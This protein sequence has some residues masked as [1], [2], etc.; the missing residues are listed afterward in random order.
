MMVRTHDAEE[1]RMTTGAL[2]SSSDGRTVALTTGAGVGLRPG[3]LLSVD[4]DDGAVLAQVLGV[5]AGAGE[6]AVVGVL[7][8][9]GALRAR[10]RPPFGERA[11]SAATAE[12]LGALQRA[13]GA[14]TVIGTWTS[15]GVEVPAAL[16]ARAFN[17]HTFLCG[18]S[19]SG[20]TYALGVVLERLL[21]GTDL[22]VVVLDPNADFARL[23]EQ[24]DGTDPTV[25]ER[26]RARGVRV[27]RSDANRTERDDPLRLR[28]LAMSRR[29]QAAVLQL[30]PVRDADEYHAFGTLMSRL[31]SADVTTVLAAL[32]EGSPAEQSLSRRLDNL[33]L[34]S[35]QAFA[36]KHHSA[37]EVVDDGAGVTVL[38][39]GGFGDPQEPVT[40]ALEVLDDLWARRE[41]RRPTLVVIDE[42][43]NVCPAEPASPAARLLVDRLVTVAAEGRKYGLWLLL[44][45]QRPSKVHPQVLSQCDN[46]VLMRMNSPADVAD[47][48]SVFGFVPPGMLAA[49]TSF[50][51]GE[52][53]VAGP[54][55]PVPMLVRMGERWTPEGG[56]DVEV[57]LAESAC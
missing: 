31:G 32:R 24:R 38:D 23:R 57:P 56:R 22:R 43:H 13:T 46:L 15:A 8:P 45:S 17:R 7:G 11:A 25:A 39:L 54:V 52:A 28:F 20:K 6:A 40:V 5:S 14:A 44:C 30:D 1:M 51:Q 21:H 33:G 37:A 27:L 55:A 29:A 49:C 36:D 26:L 41:D 10:E 19:G 2:A 50:L 18:Q 34:P 9:D 42:A 47:L 4:V 12:Q 53:L 3:D 35:W 16:R 48:A